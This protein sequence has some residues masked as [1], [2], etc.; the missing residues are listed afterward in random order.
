MSKNYYKVGKKVKNIEFAGAAVQG[1]NHVKSNIPC[2][3]YIF[4]KTLNNITVI[5][6]ADGAGSYKQTEVGAKISTEFVANFICDNFQVLFKENND[7]IAKRLLNGIRSKL[8]V[9]AKQLNLKTE[10]HDLGSTLLFVAIHNN[11]YLAGHLGDGVIGYFENQEPKVL[12]KPDNDGKYTFLTTSITAQAHFRFYKG[13]NDKIDGFILMSDGTCD[14]LYEKENNQLVSVNTTILE[15]LQENEKSSVEKE[16][17]KTIEDVFLDE[18]DNGDD[19]SINL[20]TLTR[21]EGIMDKDKK[22]DK[23]IDLKQ[24]ANNVAKNKA[25]I[26]KLEDDFS[27]IKKQSKDIQSANDKDINKVRNSIGSLEKKVEGLEGR[28]QNSIERDTDEPLLVENSLENKVK[29]L[30]IFVVLN[31]I[32]LLVMLLK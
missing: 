4:S 24:L 6:L 15:W 2:Q 16:I 30:T 26:E 18:S 32:I 8:T 12:S 10:N 29:T 7:T 19:C 21:K 11:Q 22:I 14:S 5:A 28:L 3:D 13:E 23:Q 20:L 1:I 25:K 9:K 31:I 17:H 27:S